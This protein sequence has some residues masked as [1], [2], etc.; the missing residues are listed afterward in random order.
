MKD[1]FTYESFRVMEGTT[2]SVKSRTVTVSGKFGQ[3][4]RSFNHLPVDI[5]LCG[6]GKVVRIEVWFGTP[7]HQSAINT[8]CSAIKNMMVGVMKKFEYKMRLVY[9]HFPINSNILNNGSL[10]EI[11]N[12]LGEKRVRTVKM[13]PGVVVEK[14]NAVKDELIITG[15]DLELVSRSAA[16][17]H[18]CAL[19][20]NK[21][22]RKFLDGI[23]VSEK[24]TVVKDE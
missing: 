17:I 1:I 20:R 11:R 7:R 18:Q 13:L 4:T 16:L 3:V 22:I 12:F 2:V 9:S 6:N 19:A 15:T 10:I 21:D 14:S 8:V 24:G 5:K 23:Y